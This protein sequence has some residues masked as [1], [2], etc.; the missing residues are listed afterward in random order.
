VWL[1]HKNSFISAIDS[2][3]RAYQEWS[4]NL[5]FIMST[6]IGSSP[7]F[8]RLSVV[9]P[10][11][12]G[13]QNPGNLQAEMDL[14]YCFGVGDDT[15]PALYANPLSQYYGVYATSYTYNT[16]K[17]NANNQ[18]YIIPRF[19]TNIYY[20]CDTPPQLTSEYNHFY[21]L[22]LGNSTF[23]QIIEREITLYLYRTL[24]Y[25]WDLTMFHQSNAI[26]F[27]PD[28]YGLNFI[29]SIAIINGTTSLWQIWTSS[30][31]TALTQYTT[32]PILSLLESTLGHYFIQRE[33]RDV[34]GPTGYRVVVDD[35]VVAVSY[36]GTCNAPV[37]LSVSNFASAAFKIIP[38][39]TRVDEYGP[40]L[41][42]YL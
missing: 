4:L 15:I 40:D 38:E 17:C 22:T 23:E 1:I 24:S 36:N 28:T 41:T 16:T 27:N 25:R 32:L 14:G 21:N 35:N 18:I 31:L 8:D 11:I 39:S 9:N 34:C 42:Y 5:D 20:N 29:P 2:L 3:R 30:V 37:A 19:A 26:Q 13:L 7:R 6:P 10:S 12:S 33:I